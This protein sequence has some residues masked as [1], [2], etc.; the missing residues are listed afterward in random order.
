MDIHNFSVL[1]MH[2]YVCFL[3]L[4]LD[5]EFRFSF[6][7]LTNLINTIC[8]IFPA[9]AVYKCLFM[10]GR[11]AGLTLFDMDSTP[12]DLT[13]GAYGPLPENALNLKVGGKT[14]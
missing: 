1:S 7:M 12:T 4:D 5:L 3:L 9:W 14:W 13:W 10:F 8:F 6:R 2:I 11:Y